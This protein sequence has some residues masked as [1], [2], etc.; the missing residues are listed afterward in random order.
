MRFLARAHTPRMHRH[1]PA[2][3][4]LQFTARHRP[5]TPAAPKILRAPGL[6]ARALLWA[7]WVVLGAAAGSAWATPAPETGLKLVVLDP[8]HGGPNEGAPTPY[9]PG[10]F[11]KTYT[12]DIAQRAAAHLRAAG[13]TVVLTR[14]QD[15]PLD[16]QARI[17]IAN[18]LGADVFVSVH[19]NSVER[20][21]P[22]GY[23]SFI[24]SREASDEGAERLAM[25][26]NREGD[27]LGQ[28]QRSPD[29]QPEAAPLSAVQDVLSDLAAHRAHRDAARL[30]ATVQRRLRAHTPF[31]DRG[32]KQA[33]F[34]VLK[35]ATM[36]AIVFECGF[37]NHPREGRWI[38]SLEGRKAL[39]QG[40]AL[41]I[42]D[43]GGHETP[44]IVPLKPAD[45]GGGRPAAGERPPSSAPPVPIP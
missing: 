11:E 19:L 14:E 7:L 25:F 43:F 5:I 4:P 28:L 32:V 20:P 45:L 18:R 10:A 44:P 40:L 30:A 36:P 1:L 26:E 34:G 17:L 24:L 33:N 21:G 31:P 29:G 41:A 42:L 9:D 13:V 2:S 38:I 8:G 16:L 27:L 22:V 39:A 15:I 35:G 12:L 3:Q 23:G 6:P 37:L